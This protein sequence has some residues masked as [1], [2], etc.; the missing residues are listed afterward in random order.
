MSPAYSGGMAPAYL[1]SYYSGGYGSGASD[2]A[3][4]PPLPGPL[5][6]LHTLHLSVSSIAALME[7]V[8]MNADA[9]HHVFFSALSLLERVG[10]ATGEL[11][12]FLHARPPT[13]AEGRPIV[14]PQQAKRLRNQ[15][16]ARL[17]VG[18][19]VLIASLSVLRRT[20]RSKSDAVSAAALAATAGA[21]AQSAHKAAATSGGTGRTRFQLGL[22]ALSLLCGVGIGR[23]VADAAAAAERE[24]TAH[25][26]QAGGELAHRPAEAELPQSLHDSTSNGFF[27]DSS[28]AQHPGWAA[29]RPASG[30]G[31]PT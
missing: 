20:F 8:G 28:H 26:A 27:S 13:D 12:G 6:A 1:S 9:V 24:G 18:G 30:G 15:K 2:L 16:I 4:G 17:L 14:D 7:L 10:V 3:G 29:S 22:M 19:L 25:A 5:G 31:P 21:A 11:L 23:G